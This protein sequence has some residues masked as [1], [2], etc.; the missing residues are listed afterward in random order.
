MVVDLRKSSAGKGLFLPFLDAFS[1]CFLQRT[2]GFL[3]VTA[4]SVVFVNESR[5]AARDRVT[6][7]RR[8]RHLGLSEAHSAI[9]IA[10]YMGARMQ[11]GPRFRCACRATV[12]S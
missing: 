5:W 10:Q 8:M 11:R 12:S 1:A 2:P 7:I 3:A 4:R 9:S 6:V